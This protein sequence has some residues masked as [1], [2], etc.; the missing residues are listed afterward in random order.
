PVFSNRHLP[1]RVRMGLTLI[2]ASVLVPLRR[3]QTIPTDASALAAAM[4]IEVLIGLAI[5]FAASLVFMAVQVAGELTDMSAGFTISMQFNPAFGIQASVLAQLQL[6]LATLL[7]LAIDGHHSVIAAAA[8]SYRV[9][10]LGT[11][12]STASTAHIVDLTAELFSL[13][14]RMALPAVISL[15]LTDLALSMIARTA[16]Q[17]NLFTVGMPLKMGVGLLVVL[18]GFPV[19]ASLTTDALRG[20]GTLMLRIT[21]R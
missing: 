6:T 7:F 2:V 17:I 1:A 19:L 21:A 15:I 8:D 10:P 14:V 16:P 18:A 20:V 13:G 9:L 3:P 5:G 4:V 11:A 12:L